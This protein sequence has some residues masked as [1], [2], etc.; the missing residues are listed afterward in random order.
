MIN[1][2]EICVASIKFAT[3]AEILPSRQSEAVSK[4]T[5]RICHPDR[6]QRM[7]GSDTQSVDMK[8]E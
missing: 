1:T 2:G 8:T 3:F 7:K 6:A 4:H 5:L